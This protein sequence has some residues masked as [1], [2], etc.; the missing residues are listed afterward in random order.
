MTKTYLSLISIYLLLGLQVFGQTSEKYYRHIRYNHTSP[1]V[2]ILGIY[3][4]TKN[5][6]DTTSHYVF[7]QNAKGELVEIINRHYHTQRQHPLT[8]F[9]AYRILFTY[10]ADKEV[11]TFY[12]PNGKRVTN[13]RGVYKEVFKRKKDFVTDLYFYDEEDKP[14]LSNWGV[15]RYHWKKHKKLVVENR[16]N[17]TDSSV[18]IS[19]YFAFGTTGILY[20]KNGYPK[21]T[22]N[23]D[24]NL[25]PLEN[26]AGVASYH[27][28]YDKNGNHTLYEYHD[29]DDKLTL[30]QWGFAYGTK[31]YDHKGNQI[32]RAVYDEQHKLLNER[33]DY[34]NVYTKMAP[35]VTA[36]DSSE[37]MRVALGYLIALQKLKPEL[38]NEVMHK[39]LA[40]RTI[41]FDFGEKKET[42]KETTYEQMLSFAESWNKSGNK[43]PVNPHNQVTILDIYQKAASVKLVSDNWYEYLH[44]AKI[45][46]HWKIVNLLWL[47]KDFRK[48]NY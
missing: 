29:K 32:G 26:A 24:S 35:P 12:D 3:P 7:I 27:D 36:N 1:H 28:I 44:L 43:F 47:Y 5:E 14:M 15:A 21:A 37:I 6:A 13:D 2:P 42:L 22:Y 4:I 20:D 41:G 10:D 31:K 23:L 30:N 40:K 38:M 18:N 39:Q 16:Y 34:S 17:L 48:N 25:T 46:G 33:E 11:R 45:N 8:T 9:G 19:P